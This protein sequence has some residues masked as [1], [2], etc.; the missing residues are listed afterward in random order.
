MSGP[1]QSLW[2]QADPGNQEKNFYT[3]LNKIWWN[4]LFIILLYSQK[5]INNGK[6]NK[7]HTL[8]G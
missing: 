6:E 4:E 5:Q 8:K 1:S 3:K 2:I 7:T